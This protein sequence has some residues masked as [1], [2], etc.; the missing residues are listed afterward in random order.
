MNNIEEINPNEMPNNFIYLGTSLFEC[1]YC[2][3]IWKYNHYK[4]NILHKSFLY[5]FCIGYGE[6]YKKHKEELL[7]M[8]K[9]PVKK[10]NIIKKFYNNQCINCKSE[11]NL[12][13][14]HIISVSEGGNNN[15]ENLTLLCKK[16][17]INKYTNPYFYKDLDYFIKIK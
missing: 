12:E 16:C 9:I 17:N 8:R 3:K 2:G 13:I 5:K 7:Q 1:K 10:K 4:N 15:I 6:C 14:D 11:D